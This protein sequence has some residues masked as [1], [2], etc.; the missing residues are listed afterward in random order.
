MGE[1]GGLRPEQEC[2][3][4]LRVPTLVGAAHLLS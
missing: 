4:K 2:P 3:G 1:E